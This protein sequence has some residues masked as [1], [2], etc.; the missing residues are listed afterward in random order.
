MVCVSAGGQLCLTLFNPIN[1]SLPGSS[2][3]GIFM[4]RKFIESEF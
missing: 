2:V 1:C 4:V 3:Y